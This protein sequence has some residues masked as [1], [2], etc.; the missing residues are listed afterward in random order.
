MFSNTE[1]LYPNPTSYTSSGS[2]TTA[3]NVAAATS[4]TTSNPN[5]SMM[6]QFNIHKSSTTSLPKTPQVKPNSGTSS[7]HKPP[8][9]MK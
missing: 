3:T 8:N 4:P 7:D 2:V 6:S 9:P 1:K 5:S